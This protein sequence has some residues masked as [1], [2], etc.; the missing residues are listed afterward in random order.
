MWAQISVVRQSSGVAKSAI[1]GQIKE[2]LDA[3]VRDKLDSWY[4]E[5]S[6]TTSITEDE[7]SLLIWK[8]I[9]KRSKW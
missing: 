5:L 1:Y 3:M 9:A 6:E 2:L 7:T 4:F 8:I